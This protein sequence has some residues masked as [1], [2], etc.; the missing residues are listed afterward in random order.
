MAAEFEADEIGKSVF[1]NISAF[2]RPVKTTILMGG[3]EFGTY[4]DIL[5][6]IH[7][8]DVLP[9]YDKSLY[10]RIIDRRRQ[11][12]VPGVVPGTGQ[13]PDSRA[14]V[15]DGGREYDLDAIRS[16]SVIPPLFQDLPVSYAVLNLSIALQSKVALQRVG[17]T[18][19]MSIFVEGGFRHNPDYN[20]LLASFFPDNPVFLTGIEEATSFGTALTAWAAREDAGPERYAPLFE[21]ETFPVHPESFSGITEYE[22]EFFSHI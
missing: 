4:T 16:G 5:K 3:L 20:L 7:E 22:K 2:G 9:D 14:R 15:V 21:I 1:F 12:I 17:L 13:F 18:P 10:Q 6:S 11:F 19:G 8:T